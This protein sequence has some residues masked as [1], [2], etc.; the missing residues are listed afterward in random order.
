MRNSRLVIFLGKLNNL[1]L[2]RPDIGNAYLEAVTEE[3]LYIGAGPEFEDWEGYLLT[4]SKALNG[5]D[6]KRWTEAL[7]GI[8]KDMDFILSQAD[9]C[10]WLRKNSKLNLNEYI[11][12]MLMIYA[13]HN[14]KELISILKSKYQ[15]IVQGV[16]SLPYP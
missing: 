16:D 13:A 4:L 14:P 3:K 11:P 5:L 7:Y 1:E 15:L 12:A 2:W 9:P 8:L 10:I 6:G